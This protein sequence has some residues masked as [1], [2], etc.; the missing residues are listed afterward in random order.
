MKKPRKGSDLSENLTVKEMKESFLKIE[1]TEE[2]VCR[3]LP[4]PE[5]SIVV[6]VRAAENVVEIFGPMMKPTVCLNS[7]TLLKASLLPFRKWGERIEK[8]RGLEAGDE[9]EM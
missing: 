6:L 9:N 5:K 8:A 3:Y 7:I 4:D 2:C 1:R